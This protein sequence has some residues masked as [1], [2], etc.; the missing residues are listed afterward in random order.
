MKI[1]LSRK[2][3]ETMLVLIYE[4]LSFDAKGRVNHAF[5]LEEISIIDKLERNLKFYENGEA[6][7]GFETGDICH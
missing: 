3:I 7:C 1:E 4:S 5:S 2:E 6:E